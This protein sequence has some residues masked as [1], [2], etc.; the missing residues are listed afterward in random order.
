MKASDGLIFA[1]LPMDSSDLF[2]DG[3]VLIKD[4]LLIIIC[5]E[6]ADH[7]KGVLMDQ[8]LKPQFGIF[9]RFFGI[10]S[11]LCCSYENPNLRYHRLLPQQHRKN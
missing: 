4:G 5:V 2:P 3:I 9:T 11:V 7:E 6:F 10:K 8:V 1:N